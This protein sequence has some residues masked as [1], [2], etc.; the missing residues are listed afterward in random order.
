[1]SEQIV[2]LRNSAGHALHCMFEL[3]PPGAPKTDLGCVLLSPGVKMR[4]APHRLYRKLAAEFL[5]RG[6]AVMRVDFHGLGDSEGDLPEQQLD[7]LYR[8]VQLGRHVDD[9][10][11]ALRWLQREHGLKRFVIGG[12]CGGA[13]TGLLASEVDES[14]VALYAIGIPVV[15]DASGQ[16][17]SQNMTQGQLR[18]MR[19]TYL[20]KLMNPSA[21]LRLL[22]FKSDFRSILRSLFPKLGAGAKGK[23]V[24]DTRVPPPESATAANLNPKY[25][26]AMF[27]LLQRNRS[28]LLIFSGA[29]R[30][31][32]EYQEKFVAPW[33]AALEKFASLLTVEV[34]PQ[35][36][37]VLGD[38]AWMAQARVLTGRWLDERFK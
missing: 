32:F 9:A 2:S 6:I 12:L 10:R 19:G 34:I 21:W 4:V 36:N 35:A 20:S 38:P 17:E 11:T 7:Q 30:L 3:P 24:S 13:L 27:G 26:P 15:L 23:T 18:D 28:A 33:R 1:M 8:Q 29:D 5:E 31:Q 25:A 16:H 14:V 37:H 22:S